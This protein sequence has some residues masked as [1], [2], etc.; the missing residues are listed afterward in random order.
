M[1]F[2]KASTLHM[3]SRPSLHKN[4]VTRFFYGTTAGWSRW[5]F[6]ILDREQK[7]EAAFVT[8]SLV[9]CDPGPPRNMISIAY[10]RRARRWLSRSKYLVCVPELT[11]HVTKPITRC[12]HADSRQICRA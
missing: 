5:L 10:S 7:Q 2:M 4:L 1:R 11:P 12:C 8:L 9:Q 6:V 3:K